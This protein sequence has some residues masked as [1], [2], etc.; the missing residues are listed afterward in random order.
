MDSVGIRTN[1]PTAGHLLDRSHGRGE[2]G[3]TRLR[4]H[5]NH[6]A[7]ARALHGQGL[8]VAAIHEGRASNQTRTRLNHH[9]LTPHAPVG[10]FLYPK[11]D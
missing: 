2:H 5:E 10:L 9:T 4:N 6:P 3:K 7:H 11:E 8:P 1:L